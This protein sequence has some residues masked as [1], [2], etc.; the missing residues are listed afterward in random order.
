[1]IETTGFFLCFL[2]GL[3]VCLFACFLLGFEFV[4][5]VVFNLT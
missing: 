5:V 1:M 2:V 4:V 3:F